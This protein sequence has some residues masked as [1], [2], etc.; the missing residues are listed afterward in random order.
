MLCFI[1]L[2]LTPNLADFPLLFHIM[3]VMDVSW[4]KRRLIFEYLLVPDTI[5]KILKGRNTELH[6][7]F[8]QLA[9]LCLYTLL[10]Q[11]SKIFITISSLCMK[12]LRSVSHKRVE[13]HKSVNRFMSATK[14]NESDH[15]SVCYF[16]S[17]WAMCSDANELVDREQW[18]FFARDKKWTWKI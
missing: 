18:S 7:V 3:H 4:C 5:P 9:G 17:S 16:W 11:I 12:K 14:E 2:S 8:F 6:W 15:E 13:S 10:L 1:G